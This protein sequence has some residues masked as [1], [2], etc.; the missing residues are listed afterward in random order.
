[1]ITIRDRNLLLVM[2]SAISFA[3]CQ[4]EP[5]GSSS[6]LESA[7]FADSVYFG[8]RIYTVDDDRSWAEAVA[9]KD[10]RFLAV[11][12]NDE[13]L[14][15]AGPETISRDLNGAMAMP[16]IQDSHFHLMSANNSIDCSPP[17]FVPEQLAAV[18]AECRS[19]QVPGHPW[20]MINGMEMWDGSALS[21]ELV[22]EAFPDTPVII[23]DVTFHNRLVNDAAL[24]IAGIDESTPDPEGGKILKDPETGRPTGVLAEWS[25]IDL[26]EQHVPPY[27]DAVLDRSLALLFEG[28]LENGIT[29]IQEALSNRELLESIARVDKSGVRMPYVFDHMHWSFENE[30]LRQQQEALIR[31]RAQFESDHV[32]MYAIKLFLDGVPVPPAFTHVPIG[33]DGTVDETNLLIP[34]D[35]LIDKVTEWDKAGLKVKMHSAGDGAVRIGLDTIEAVRLANG[36]SD[37]WHEIGHTTNISAADLPRF[38]EIKAAAEVSPYLWILEMFAGQPG[39]QF[40]SLHENGALVTIGSDY[41]VV[42]SFNPFPPLQGIVT[43]DGESVPIAVAL[44]FVTRNAA[45]SVG[46]LEG[47]GTIEP[48]KIANMIVLDRNL[49]EIES[50]EIGATVVTMTVLDGNIVYEAE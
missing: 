40:R 8:G 6:S 44:D 10:G 12:S 49:L 21:N 3:G 22:N 33:A 19:Q 16:G 15:L 14:A 42:E 5:A 41:P 35:V 38:A 28:L 30:Q 2:I 24:A 13:I 43:R 26:V 23:R 18:L 29:S 9:I 31:D 48:G 50:N 46:R 11:G 36:D 7:A 32:F 39:F 34:R 37:I 47:M 4:N 27:D 25:A 17:Q 1:M 45:Q 20:L